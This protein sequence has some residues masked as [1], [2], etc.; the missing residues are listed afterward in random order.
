MLVTD[1]HFA[2]I[3]QLAAAVSVPLKA[4]KYMTYSD[5]HFLVQAFNKTYVSQGNRFEMSSGI[6]QAVIYSYWM[7]QIGTQ[8]VSCIGVLCAN[9]NHRSR[10][11]PVVTSV[12]SNHYTAR[13][14][15]GG[16]TC[17]HH[18]RATPSI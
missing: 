13:R 4:G 18:S 8:T 10:Q 3:E 6:P 9:H 14:E 2:G 7:F 11:L 5:F 15:R 1:S 16:I 17:K 12:P